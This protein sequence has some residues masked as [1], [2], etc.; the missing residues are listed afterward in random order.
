VT[1][2]FGFGFD[3]VVVATVLVVP[4]VAESAPWPRWTSAPTRAIAATAARR[5][6]IRTGTEATL[7]AST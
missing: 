3:A 2:R 6:A 7:S 5:I 1:T 4:A